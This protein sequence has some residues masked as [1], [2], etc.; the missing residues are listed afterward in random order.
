V[1]LTPIAN[2]LHQR[3]ARTRSAGGVS[4]AIAR[5]R[6]GRPLIEN[7]FD[8]DPFAPSQA[9]AWGQ[10]FLFGLTGPFESTE[11][12][13]D[14]ISEDVR[15]AFEKG[16]LSGQQAA[17]D[18]LDIFPQCVDTEEQEHVPL[19]AELGLEAAGF[20]VELIEAAKLASAAFSTCFM[21]ALDIALAAHH[22]TPPEEVIDG[23]TEKFF[24][25]IEALG[26]E[27]CN[28][29]IGG[30][31]D[32][33]AAGCQLKLTPLFR[34]PEQ[35]HDAAVSFGRPVFFVGEWHA[36]QCGR[37]KLIEGTTE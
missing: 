10:G 35:A 15:E 27:D 6:R 1:N 17:I 12:A 8:Q 4:H 36:N 37:M 25:T 34:T 2:G 13:P 3:H 18:G 28:F 7:P 5:K 24:G 32:L 26:H 30:A 29:F 20:A 14:E 16:V 23:I 9:F 33:E 19:A 22:F 31:V 11:Q 21:A